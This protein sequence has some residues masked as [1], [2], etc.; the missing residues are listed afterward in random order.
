MISTIHGRQALFAVHNEYIPGITLRYV[1]GLLP[2]LI[3][4]L[5]RPDAY[6]RHRL[7][8]YHRLLVWLKHGPGTIVAY[9]FLKQRGNEIVRGQVRQQYGAAEASP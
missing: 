3:R 8:N 2:D 4:Q 6:L 7:T 1:Y 5:G 9:L